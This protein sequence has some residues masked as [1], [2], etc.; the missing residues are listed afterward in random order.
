M[1]NVTSNSTGLGTRIREL[2]LARDMRIEDLAS[3]SGL[4]LR[5]I[6]RIEGGKEARLPTLRKL[7][8]ALDTTVAHLID[9]EDVA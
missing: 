4:A 8:A 2:R 3:V 5:T 6:T 1:A 9:L 7:A